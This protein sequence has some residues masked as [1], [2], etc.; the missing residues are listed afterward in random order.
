MAQD[1]THKTHARTHRFTRKRDPVRL[2]PSSLG[3]SNKRVISRGRTCHSTWSKRRENTAAIC[4]FFPLPSGSFCVSV[5]CCSV[6]TV[7][8]PTQ[9]F[10]SCHTSCAQHR[11]PAPWRRRQWRWQWKVGY[12]VAGRGGE[13]PHWFLGKIKKNCFQML[14]AAH[15]SSKFSHQRPEDKR[16]H[17]RNIHCTKWAVVQ[18]DSTHVWFTVNLFFFPGKRIWNFKYNKQK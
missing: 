11:W 12:L 5:H 7:H 15:R 1:Q 6:D 14:G 10:P 17:Q 4:I 9:G 16:Y 2:P 3:W 18:P 8:S 13:T